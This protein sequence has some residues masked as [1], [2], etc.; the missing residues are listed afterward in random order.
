[1]KKCE[2]SLCAAIIV[3]DRLV[4]RE[5]LAGRQ[6]DLLVFWPGMY[7]NLGPKSRTHRPTSNSHSLYH[8]A[9]AFGTGIPGEESNLDQARV[10]AR[11]RL[12][13]CCLV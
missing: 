8:M 10:L 13:P 7:S 9:R 12:P 3:N 4:G 6:H 2:W 5:A 11:P 1:M